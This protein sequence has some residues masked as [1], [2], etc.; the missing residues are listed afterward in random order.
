[1]GPGDLFV[2][3][4]P[5]PSGITPLGA[6][7]LN[8]RGEWVEDV[9]DVVESLPRGTLGLIESTMRVDNKKIY[10]VWIPSISKFGWLWWHE[11]EVIDGT[12]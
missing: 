5:T 2:V 1:M 8:E 6:V 11:M 10:V 3:K 12:G 9:V 4:P 7:T